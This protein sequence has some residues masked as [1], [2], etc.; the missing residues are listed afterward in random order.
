MP[1]RD[2]LPEAI[3]PLARRNAV[4]LTHE[5]FRADAQGLVKAIQQA[6]EEASALRQ[7]QVDAAQKAHSEEAR[8]RNEEAARLREKTQREVEEQA[9]REKERAR[10]TAIVG[11]SPEYVAKAEELANWDFIKESSRPQDFRDHLA[12]YP[13]GASEAWARHRLAALAWVALGATP[14]REALESYLN[15]FPDGPHSKQARSGLAALDRAKAERAALHRN[16]EEQAFEAAK[17]DDCA[18]A[19]AQFLAAYPD[20]RLS[21]KARALQAALLVRDQ[22]HKSAMASGNPAALKA[23]LDTYPTG[24]PADEVCRRL[25]RLD[26]HPAWPPSRRAVLVGGEVIGIMLVVAAIGIW[27]AATGPMRQ[28]EVPQP[29][30]WMVITPQPTPAV[31]NAMVNGPD[32]DVPLSPER[33]RPL[34][35]KDGFKECGKCPE[36]V[37][38]PAGSFTMG[39]SAREAHRHDNEGPQHLV[40][41]AKPF[42]V[43]RFAVTFDEWDACIAEGGCNSHRPGD[44]GWGRGRRPV[45]NVSWD[46]AQAYVAWLSKKTGKTYR[47]LS[48]AEREYVTRAGT[49]TPFWWGSSIS[50]SQANYLY[51]GSYTYGNVKTLPVDSFKPNAWGLYQVHGNVWE[52]TQDCYQDTYNGAPADGS[53]RTSG[54]CRNHVVRG[55]SRGNGSQDLRAATRGT[56]TG[57]NR[58]HDIGFRLGRTLIP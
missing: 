54:D 7:A 36:M 6:L 47:L 27:L 33:E 31:V 20:S 19:I 13:R 2:E 56:S 51:F 28:A 58:N 55:G 4:R 32:N 43:G 17:R 34:K 3:R 9:R 8:K 29:P 16:E 21:A 15:E 40:T 45:I 42:A 53:A 30:A 39:S 18:A 22:A 38:V 49:T 50:T 37:A 11:L 25:R 46:D 44:E 10:L 24:G 35:P 1:S 14:D 48:E 41:V 52:W 26:R 57:G 5:R 23:F 12:R